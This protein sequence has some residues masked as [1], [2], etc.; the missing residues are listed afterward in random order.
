MKQC[1]EAFN[2]SS[3]QVL[4]ASSLHRYDFL[5]RVKRFSAVIFLKEIHC[6]NASL[7]LLFNVALPTSADS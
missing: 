2:T 4:N 7:L 3:L 6:L 1:S 5:P